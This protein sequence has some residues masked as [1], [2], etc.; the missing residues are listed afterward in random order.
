MC[1]RY[2]SP[3]DAH[4]EQV[5]GIGAR[6]PWRGGGVFPRS[7]GPF[8]RCLRDD[9]G[10]S[11]EMVVGQW[12]LI[13]WFAK[14]AKLPYSTNNARSEELAA[15]ASYKHPWAR[16]QRCIIPAVSFDERKRSLNYVFPQ[17]A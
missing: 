3:T 15:K 6:N 16:G 8:I 10:Y 4:I 12:G 1:N 13:P 14:A 5:W 11:R 7:P 2:V 17:S 9:T